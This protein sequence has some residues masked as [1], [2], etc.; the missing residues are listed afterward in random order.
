MKKIVTKAL[1]I[2]DNK[3]RRQL[4][5]LTLF[6]AL[7]SIADITSLVFLLALI[8]LYTKP[9]GLSYKWLPH[10]SL[11]KSFL[12][13]II[14]FFF[15]FLFKNTLGYFIIKAQYHF[16][17][18]V[19]S[20]L[21]KAGIIKFLNG[22][23]SDYVYIDNSVRIRQIGHQPIEF[24]NYV[25]FG[26]IQAGT[27]LTLTAL[28]IIAILLFNAKLFL[29]LLVILLP[30]VLLAS[31]LTKRK[32][33]RARTHIQSNM[34]KTTQFLNEALNSYIESNIYHSKPFFYNR[35]S[36]F[37]KRLNTHL[38]ELQITQAVPSR[39]IEVFAVLGLFILILVNKYSNGSTT[40]LVNV[41]A[42]MAAAY[43]IIP[44]ITRIAN[45][46]AQIRL[47]AFSMNEL[48]PTIASAQ[49]EQSNIINK[50]IKTIEFKNVSFNYENK[51]VLKHFNAS[52][53]QGDFVGMASA[54]GKGKTTIINLLLGFIACNNGEILINNFSNES[55]DRQLYWDDIAYIKQQVFLINDTILHN[56][57]LQETGYNEQRFQN[58]IKASGLENFIQSFS[59][60]KEKIISDSGKNVSGGQRQRIALARALYKNAGVIIL[61][62]AFSELDETSE[63]DILKHLKALAQ[64]GRIILLITHHKKSLEL[65]NKVISINE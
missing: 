58:A 51:Q 56:I 24:C 43:K 11:N 63:F 19:A 42:F 47:Y 16:V 44:G 53:Q 6:N 23:Y 65:C 7:L 3:E 62:E 22:N 52:L 27:E 28:A 55:T 15:L 21:S 20:R 10:W 39:F 60:G 4:S 45:L 31:Y 48:G 14:I 64:E 17:Y 34:E 50:K 46:T 25:L 38:S 1:S 33:K 40:E 57:T 54:S 49:Q 26:L 5:R 29:L 35:Y 13:P 9:E 36:Q 18:N 12:L 32:L 30:P 8:Q 59:E 61:D 41:G 2:L 37:Q